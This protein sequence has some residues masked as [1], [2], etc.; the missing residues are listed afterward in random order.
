MLNNRH[1]NREAHQV[2]FGR[3]EEVVL[4]EHVTVI[5]I[6]GGS[7][8]VDG[9][10]SEGFVPGGL[11][12]GIL[13]LGGSLLFASNSDL[14]VGIG[15]VGKRAGEI[16]SFN[17]SDVEGLGAVGLLTSSDATGNSGGRDGLLVEVEAEEDSFVVAQSTNAATIYTVT[18]V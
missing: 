14:N 1:T 12:S 3:T 4:G 11:L 16:E 9:G 15:L 10:V 18:A 17:N 13:L 7:G 8:G 6:N 2:S 5:N